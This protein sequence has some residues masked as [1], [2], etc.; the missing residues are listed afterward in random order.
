MLIDVNGSIICLP[1]QAVLCLWNPSRHQVLPSNFAP[2]RGNCSLMARSACLFDLLSEGNQ[3]VSRSFAISFGIRGFFTLK[4]EVE[5]VALLVFG[6]WQATLTHHFIEAKELTIPQKETTWLWL[7]ATVSFQCRTTVWRR[8]CFEVSSCG[9]LGQWRGPMKFQPLVSG[10]GCEKT[11]QYHDRYKWNH[12]KDLMEKH[13]LQRCSWKNN[14]DD[15][16]G[17]Q[18]FP[19]DLVPQMQKQEDFEITT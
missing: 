7:V 14:T 16:S 17:T 6:Y 2:T 9:W 18:Q 5:D 12:S 11:P 13:S 8:C 10:L 1:W 19:S 3:Q 4:K 15:T